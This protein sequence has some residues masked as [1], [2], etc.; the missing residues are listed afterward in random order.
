MSIVRGRFSKAILLL[1][2]AGIVLSSC[3]KIETPVNGDPEQFAYYTEEYPPLNYSDNGQA[4]GISVDLLESVFKRLGVGLDRNNIQVTSWAEAY[5]HTLITPNTMIFSTVK[6]SQRDSLFKWV[7]PI[8]P[9]QDVA[10]FLKNG[11]VQLKDVTD[12]NNYFTGVIDGY[13]SMNTLLDHGVYRANIIIYKD[14]EELYE[15]LVVYREIQCIAYGLA[16]H[17]LVI[18]SLGYSA[19]QFGT[20]FTIHSEELWYAFNA[21]TDQQMIDDFQKQLNL[22][23]TEKATDGSSEYEKIL[24]RYSFIQ[25]GTD[26]ITE[27]MVIDLVNQTVSDLENDAITTID[28]IN[29]GLA[30][31]KDPVNSALYSFVYDTTIVMVAHAD[32]KSLVGKSF[33]GKPDA[34]GKKFRDEI[35]RGALENG[36][37]WEDYVYT[38]PDQSGLYYKTTYYKLVT[39]SNKVKY[40]I[41]AGRYK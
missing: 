29:Q 9:H 6:T 1:V 8:A 24:N 31:Y 36:S 5:S 41:C 14:L 40:I 32:N 38:R 34:T 23:K 3:K 27:K 20:P 10:I 16:G 26:G 17:N 22:L 7:G 2:S 35:V 21:Q 25:F 39:A 18:Q 4:N 33:A 11:P 19:E 13:S 30:P 15:A 12:L 37:G 28:K